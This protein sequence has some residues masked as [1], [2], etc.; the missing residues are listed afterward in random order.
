VI[1]VVGDAILDH[2]I[3]AAES[4]RD[5]PALG[6]PVHRTAEEVVAPGG[7]AMVAAMVRALGVRTRFLTAADSLE[8]IACG[9][10]RQRYGVPTWIATDPGRRPIIKSRI[11]VE[12]DPIV[13]LDSELAEEVSD[14]CERRLACLAADARLE[15]FEWC[16][17]ADYGKGTV[18]RYLA[19]QLATLFGR[20]LIVDPAPGKTWSRWGGAGL[21]KCNTAQA[22]DRS[23]R[24]LAD[25]NGVPR[26]VVTAGEEGCETWAPWGGWITH[27]RPAKAVD[28]TGCGDQFLAGLA[29]SL[30]RG[31]CLSTAVETA[32]LLASLQVTRPR[33]EPVTIADLEALEECDRGHALAA[34]RA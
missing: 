13:R 31:T 28:P 22:A 7:A 29:A 26:V 34:L 12:G 1:L 24:H 32:N 16:V 19:R 23:P 30:S 20:K 14:A 18:T 9:L 27:G 10:L 6:C 33:I 15:G 5:D 4:L 21:L 2:W 11:V 25:E 3:Y 8:D 17:V